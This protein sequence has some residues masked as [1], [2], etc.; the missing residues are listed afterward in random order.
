MP[1]SKEKSKEIYDYYTENGREKTLKKYGA[2]WE[3]IRRAFRWAKNN[4]GQIQKPSAIVQRLLDK[5]TPAELEAI[6]YG[7]SIQE[8]SRVHRIKFAGKKVRF[9]FL[10]DTHIGSRDFHEEYLLSAF[11]EYKRQGI[12]FIC[13]AGD[14]TEGMSH[15]QG[16]VYE[17]SHIGYSEQK[18]YAIE[19]FGKA[20]CKVYAIDGNHDR[21]YIKSNGAIIV[22]DIADALG[23]DRFEFLG[24]DEGRIKI[25]GVEVRLFHGEDSS[26][27]DDM[28]EIMTNTGWKYFKDLLKS[29]KVA[30][31]TKDTNEFQWQQPTDIHISDYDGDMIHFNSRTVDCM[32]TPNH[33]MW[34]R[35][36]PVY[37]N[38]TNKPVNKKLTMPQKAHYK[39]NREWHRKNAQDIYNEYTKQK[40]QFTQVS[41]LWSGETPEYIRIPKRESKNTGVKV[42]HL[43]CVHVDDIAELIAW[44]VTEGHARKYYTSISQ[45][46]TVNPEN[47]AQILSLAK[48]LNCNYG[49]SKKNIVLHSAELSEY[50]ISECGHKSRNKYLP[51]WLK[52]CDS[53]ILRI[54]FD[55]MISGDGWLTPCGFG[56]RSISKRLLEDFAEIAIKLGY[57]ITFSGDETVMVKSIQV[58]P[59]VNELP[60]TIKYKGKV[61][62]CSVP[63]G[64]IFVRRNGKTLWTHNSYA[65]S[66]RIQK[67]VE[68]M[69]GGE[70]PN[71]LLVG[72][73]HKTI[74]MPSERNVHCFSGGCIQVQTA[75]MRGKRIRADVGFWVIDM[76]I[77]DGGVSRIGGSFYPFY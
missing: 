37:T 76:E 43:G 6:A 13:H 56:Y 30:T 49:Y 71:V 24:H 25:N 17:L 27:F 51:L 66:Y 21:W 75:W 15:R 47:H 38:N 2:N 59:T 35:T 74:M 26:C 64:L 11:D 4:G 73:T 23:A 42:K 46:E 9:G 53:G 72:H 55:T 68:A 60:H 58:N 41:K 10:A 16:H 57:A 28:T 50:L 63:N 7:H 61:Y 5:Y 70:K 3:T 65:T 22:K 33:G 1:Y 29:D 77:A 52:N 40:W 34:T 44:Y 18:K 36:N 8:Q 20:P 62:C 69:R 67:L 31:M 32:V 19:L 39:N 14:V 45:Y 12:Q 54:V 48:R